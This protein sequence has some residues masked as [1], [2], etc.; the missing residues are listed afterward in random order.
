MK[1]A[2]L[3]GIAALLL[4]TGAA[5]ATVQLPEA[6]L[7]DWCSSDKSTDNRSVFFRA[8]KCPNN[9]EEDITVLVDGYET[10]WANCT[11]EKLEQNGDVYQGRSF[12]KYDKE[13]AGDLGDYVAVQDFELDV[14]GQ[15]I[16]T[17][18]SES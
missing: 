13:R 1:K 3:T 14:D 8:D 4:A 18:V 12:C 15:L 2:L 10:M 17:D 16:V 11:F 9:P 7:G 5:H 6:M